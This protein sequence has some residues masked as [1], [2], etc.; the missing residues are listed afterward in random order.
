MHQSMYF[1]LKTTPHSFQGQKKSSCLE[2]LNLCHPS[3]RILLSTFHFRSTTWNCGLEIHLYMYS[4][5]QRLAWLWMHSAR[6]ALS[7]SL[8]MSILGFDWNVLS[9]GWLVMPQEVTTFLSRGFINDMIEF[10]HFNSGWISRVRGLCSVFQL[11]LLET[12][13][14]HSYEI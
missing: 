1:V 9:P 3:C 4:I 6:Y 7:I 14:V 12:E 8:A 2:R 11:V 5:A 13:F 10:A